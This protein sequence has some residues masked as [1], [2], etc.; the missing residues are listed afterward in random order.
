MNFWIFKGNPE[1]FHIDERL[2]DPEPNT[3][4]RVKQHQDEVQAGDIA[5]IWVTGT[6]RGIRAIMEITSNPVQMTE[7]KS[8]E[9]YYIDLEKEPVMRVSGIFRE[10]FAL[11]SSQTLKNIPSLSGLSVFH[12]FTRLTNYKMTNKE[13]EVLQQYVSKNHD[14][15]V[16]ASQRRR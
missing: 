10:R 16:T 1:K 5:F 6:K 7:L 11:I 2:D 8:E 14:M 13:G 15:N 3:T 12:G 9:K 4:W